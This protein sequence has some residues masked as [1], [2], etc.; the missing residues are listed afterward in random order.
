MSSATQLLTDTGKLQHHFQRCL[1]AQRALFVVAAQI[2]IDQAEVEARLLRT[3]DGGVVLLHGRILAGSET[4]TIR[5][6]EDGA[7]Q[8]R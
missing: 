3:F 1:V 2:R 6:G 8:T 5:P 7:P 4:L